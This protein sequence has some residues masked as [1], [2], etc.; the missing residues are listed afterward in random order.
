MCQPLTGVKMVN[1]KKIEHSNTHTKLDSL[2]RTRLIEIWMV[3]H[4]AIHFE[5][6]YWAASDSKKESIPSKNGKFLWHTKI[7]ITQKMELTCPLYV[8]GKWQG[9]II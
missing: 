9:Q 5:D 1:K 3:L 4:L 7:L 8:W 2:Q 6:E